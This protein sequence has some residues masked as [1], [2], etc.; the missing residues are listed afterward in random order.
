MAT[1]GERQHAVERR[2]AGDC[3]ILREIAGDRV[4][5]ASDCA[6]GREEEEEGEGGGASIEHLGR[7]MVGMPRVTKGGLGG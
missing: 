2:L 6:V 4:P 7:V 5:S 1:W 3:G